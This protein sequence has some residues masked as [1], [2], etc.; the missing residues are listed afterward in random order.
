MSADRGPGV[1]GWLARTLAL[2]AVLA[3][4]LFALQLLVAILRA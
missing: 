2:G 1:F 3:F 4:V